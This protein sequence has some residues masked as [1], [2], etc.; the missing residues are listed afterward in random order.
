MLY[1]LY[2]Q[3]GLHK[4]VYHDEAVKLIGSGGW[5]DNTVY[6]NIE[7]KD[8]AYRR[9]FIHKDD[10]REK[11]RYERCVERV[12]QDVCRKGSSTEEGRKSSGKDVRR[13][14]DVSKDAKEEVANILP[15]KKRGRPRKVKVLSDASNKSNNE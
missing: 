1:R 13:R 15:K 11:P 9:L 8:N 12:Q 14:S 6:K 7:E 2:H 4:N 3:S 10:K 5:Y